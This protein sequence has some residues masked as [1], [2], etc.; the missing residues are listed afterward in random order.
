[1]RDRIYD[2]QLKLIRRAQDE[3]TLRRD[4]VPEDVILF[5]LATGGIISATAQTAP[6]T[7]RRT[8]ALITASL[9]AEH[10]QPLPLPP[11][12]QDLLAALKVPRP[13]RRP[14]NVSI[15]PAP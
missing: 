3:G 6:D 1:M 13:G 5:L 7:W 15:R 10:A 4:L 2:A 14:A 8:F 9:R 11:R 12:P